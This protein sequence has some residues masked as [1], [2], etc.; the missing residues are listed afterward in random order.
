MYQYPGGVVSIPVAARM[1]SV[2]TTRIRELIGEG[3]LP[4]IEDMPCGEEHDRFVPVDALFGLPTLL[5][6]GRP[7]G[8]A[9]G[10]DWIEAAGW[11]VNPWAKRLGK[12][13]RRNNS[14][15]NSRF[16]K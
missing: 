12:P 14:E 10:A 3:R 7:P 4:V 9:H 16:A 2:S 11:S 5:E 6:T 15:Q 1:M 8:W 13:V